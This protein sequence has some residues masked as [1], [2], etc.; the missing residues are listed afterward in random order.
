ME[1]FDTILISFVKAS[2]KNGIRLDRNREESKD[3]FRIL[4]KTPNP[5]SR[6]NSVIF[7]CTTNYLLWS[8]KSYSE[9]HEYIFYLFET[10][11]SG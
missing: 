6:E 3:K 7:R 8:Y 5:D 11:G 4:S 1:L 10:V 2:T 9:A